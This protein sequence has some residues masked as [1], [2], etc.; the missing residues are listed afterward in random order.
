LRQKPLKRSFR[1]LFSELN[2]KNLK[3]MTKSQLA[4]AVAS[5]LGVSK[6]QGEESIE[7]VFEVI[8]EAMLKGD[9]ANVAGFGMFGVSFGKKAP[10]FRPS[11]DLKE[12]VQKTM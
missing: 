3:I 4:D 10:K 2:N 9:K 11:K 12:A 1:A 8:R 5:K 6:K 7:K